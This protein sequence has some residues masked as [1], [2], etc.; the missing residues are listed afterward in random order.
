MNPEELKSVTAKV[1]LY[2]IGSLSLARYEHSVRVAELSRELCGRFGLDPDVGYL[3][4]LAHDICKSGKDSWLLELATKDGQP[5]SDIERRKPSLLHGHAAAVLL[6][7]MFGIVDR[8]ILFA[9]RNHTFGAPDMDALG[10]IVFNDEGQRRQ[11]NA[12]THPAVASAFK[13]QVDAYIGTTKESGLRPT[14]R[15][16][17]RLALGFPRRS[18]IED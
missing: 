13:E 15:P 4:G 12:L 8:S 16:T 11:L 5:V 18:A 1:N 6:E 2:A 9:V 7:R 17:A 3:A 10:K 14:A